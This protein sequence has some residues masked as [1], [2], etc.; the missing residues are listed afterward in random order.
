MENKHS[1]T[2]Y[3]N[4]HKSHPHF[5]HLFYQQGFSHSSSIQK[6]LQEKNFCKLVYFLTTR[7]SVIGRPTSLARNKMSKCDK[8]IF[9]KDP[10]FV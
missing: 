5:V 1:L 4:L 9:W 3:I 6:F 10:T 2:K 7:Y 8:T